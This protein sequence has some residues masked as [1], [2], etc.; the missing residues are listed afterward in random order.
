MTIHTYLPPL[1]THCSVSMPATPIF[2]LFLSLRG[3]EPATYLLLVVGQPIGLPSHTNRNNPPLAPVSSPMI[4]GGT[5]ALRAQGVPGG[6]IGRRSGGGGRRD[7]GG[8]YPTAAAALGLGTTLNQDLEEK[9]EAAVSSVGSVSPSAASG[10]GGGTAFSGTRQSQSMEGQTT[11]STVDRASRTGVAG[12][13]TSCSSGRSAGAS[14]GM[15]GGVDNVTA[16][17]AG[18]GDFAASSAAVAPQR[19]SSFLGLDGDGRGGDVEGEGSNN[20]SSSWNSVLSSRVDMGGVLGRGDSG[21]GLG[22]GGAGGVV[23][24]DGGDAG[25]QGGGAGWLGRLG[26]G[27]GS[28]RERIMPVV[29]TRVEATQVEIVEVSRAV[30]IE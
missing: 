4:G 1:A 29:V 27:G 24:R 16:S 28:E 5:T 18:A 7:G 15:T 6:S 17:G 22:G 8:V 25:V 13:S 12:S 10:A 14:S 20:A 26:G 3:I 9:S 30:V 21:G 2:Y 11:S 23:G 19:G